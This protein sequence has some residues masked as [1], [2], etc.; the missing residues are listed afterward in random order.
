M[1]RA[2]CLVT[3]VW[4]APDSSWDLSPRPRIGAR[5][6]R[7]EW[8]ARYGVREC[9]LYRRPERELEVVEFA[10][11]AV[12]RRRRFAD[13]ERIASGVLPEFDLSVAAILDRGA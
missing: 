5:R 8:F 7:L 10:A 4:G 11:G 9:W 2:T 6:G 13:A 12:S 3:I 1:S